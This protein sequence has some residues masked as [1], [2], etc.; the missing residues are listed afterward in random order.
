[1]PKQITI[2]LRNI[3]G[4]ETAYPACDASREFARLAGTRALNTAALRSIRALGYEII[5]IDQR[6][7]SA[8]LAVLSA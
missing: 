8:L 7:Q 3:S 6:T 1:M 2:E 5:V 4:R